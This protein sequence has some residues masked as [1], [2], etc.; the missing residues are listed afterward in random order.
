MKK[1]YEQEPQEV[2]IYNIN[3]DIYKLI[4][5]ENYKDYVADSY[6]YIVN[7][8]DIVKDLAAN[9]DKWLESAKENDNYLAK[10]ELISSVLVGLNN[11][12]YK[13]LKCVEKVIL[14]LLEDGVIKN[15]DLPYNIVDV[16]NERQEKRDIINS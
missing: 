7:S 16:I 8:Q 4:F 14:K 2:E 1:Y 6:Y 13:I 15:E 10:E 9:K 11:S 12:D 5:N 3:T